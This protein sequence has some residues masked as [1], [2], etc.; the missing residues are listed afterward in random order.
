MAVTMTMMGM[1]LV[2]L[3][4]FCL[5]NRRELFRESEVVRALLITPRVPED[6]RHDL[7]KVLVYT[8]RRFVPI[9][10]LCSSVQRILLS[11]ICIAEREVLDIVRS[12]V[13][14]SVDGIELVNQAAIDTL[15]LTKGNVKV[16]RYLVD[17]KI[18]IDITA[19]PFL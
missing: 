6:S 17:F 2:M 8:R 12:V 18:A 5:T 1:V 10:N 7:D 11:W 19:L 4:V 3:R 9:N 15:A 13:I 14:L 16:S